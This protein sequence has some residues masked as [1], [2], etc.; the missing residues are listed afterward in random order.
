MEKVELI[1]SLLWS[2]QRFVASTS[3]KMVQ[4]NA[5]SLSNKSCLL[6]DHI[7]DKCLDFICFTETWQQPDTFTSLN[8]NCHTGYGYLQKAHSTGLGGGLSIGVIWIY[9][10]CPYLTCAHLNAWHLNVSPPP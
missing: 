1:P 8:E 5:Q 2:V 10:H 9:P 7:L 6:R 4:F 3:I